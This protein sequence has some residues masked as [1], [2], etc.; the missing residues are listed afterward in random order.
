MASNA[1]IAEMLKAYFPEDYKGTLVEVGAGHPINI[2]F[3][4]HFR[5]LGWDI[6]SIEP[7]PEHCEEFRKMGLPILQFACSKTDKKI[8]I[9]PGISSSF[10]YKKRLSAP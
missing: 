6:V 4:L 1:E 10:P 3:S 5:P 9:L 2:S 7:I 8:F